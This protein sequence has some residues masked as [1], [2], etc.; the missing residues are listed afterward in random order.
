M[1]SGLMKVHGDIAQLRGLRESLFSKSHI[2]LLDKAQ[3]LIYISI[4][5]NISKESDGLS[6][7]LELL[8]P[9]GASP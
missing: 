8:E 5:A 7:L 4:C 1:T 2:K 6:S 3:H 9:L